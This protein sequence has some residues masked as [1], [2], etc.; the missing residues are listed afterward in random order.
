MTNND[1][2]CRTL[3][4]CFVLAMVALI[5][6]RFVELG[7]SG[8][9]DYSTS[10][11]L[12]ASTEGTVKLPEVNDVQVVES[13]NNTLEA[14]CVSEKDVDKGLTKIVSLMNRPGITKAEQEN[15]SQ[16]IQKIINSRCE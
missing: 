10:S 9:F 16:M 15:Y 14:K 1:R 3:I 11:V 7:E 12:G 6:L 4:V 13:Q 5:P 2:T 8:Y